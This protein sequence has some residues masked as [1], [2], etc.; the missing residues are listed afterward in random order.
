V[1]ALHRA[2]SDWY[3]ASGD[4]PEAISHAL[5]GGANERAA[6]LTELALPE[7]RRRRENAALLQWLRALPEDVV[8]RRAILAACLAWVRLSEGDLDGADAWLDAADEGLLTQPAA[9]PAGPDAL[10]PAARDRDDE[11]RT[12]PAMIA[13]YRASLAQAR[14]DVAGTVA[15]ARRAV[16]LAG[17][18]DH[19]VRGAGS[20]FLGLAAWAAGDLHA[21]VDTFSDAVASLHSAGN[22]ADE[23]G[24]TVV[25][26]TMWLGRGQPTRARRLYERA[27]AAAERQPHVAL[28]VTGDLHVGLADVLREQDDLEAAAAHLQTA[29]ELGDAA[30]LL[31]NRYRWYTAMAALRHAQGDLEGAVR[32]LEA[33]ATRYL[34]GFFPD[35]RP[36]PAA[37][38]RI[39]IAQ[40]RIADAWDWAREH[41]VTAVDPPS[42]LTEFN[43]LTLARLLI[44]QRTQ[45]GV[46]DALALLDR[47]VD[48]AQAADRGGSVVEARLVRALA[49]QR[50]G[51][52]AEAMPDLATALAAG[53]PAGYVR[54]FLDEGPAA[55]ELLHRVERHPE[56]A[57]HARL[58][59]R[60]G[61]HR[62]SAAPV[63][64]ADTELSE[65]EVE[66]LRLL[67]TELSGPE[68]ARRLFVSV[69][70]L[71]THSKHIFTKLDV[72]TRRAAVRRGTELGL[73]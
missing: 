70:T 24:A 64:V 18:K 73:L 42:Y 38:A 10:A 35:V 66:V 8:R 60:A 7:A 55:E 72:T 44:A 62:Q 59:L 51:E 61:R 43:Q 49:H 63:P 56:V 12:L 9:S 21:A 52:A 57:E 39:H 45:N 47:I 19:F 17:P 71:R 14:G 36:I 1:P 2:A 13:V 69:N 41:R 67:A 58:L 65:R 25:L 54:L 30:S 3:A 29:R 46:R 28:P 53:V 33:A 23:L 6:D 32:M 68:I 31:E 4:L 16:E 50:A 11:V 5:A 26:A 20:G 22:F 34:P 15:Q 48:A 27:L 37:I 40:G